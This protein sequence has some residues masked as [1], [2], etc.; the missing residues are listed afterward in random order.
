MI[1]QLLDARDLSVRSNIISDTLL[2]MINGARNYIKNHMQDRHPQIGAHRK[3]DR[4][5]TQKRQK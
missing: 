2:D 3:E 5:F 4:K 1:N